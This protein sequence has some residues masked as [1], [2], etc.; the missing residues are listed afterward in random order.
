ML[1]YSKRVQM[2]QACPIKR[3]RHIMRPVSLESMTAVGFVV[4][5]LSFPARDLTAA[6]FSEPLG[7]LPASSAASPKVRDHQ[8]ALHSGELGS[9]SAPDHVIDE[10]H[11]VHPELLT[12]VQQH[13]LDNEGEATGSR[14]DSKGED[15]EAVH[16]PVPPEAQ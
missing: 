6:T 3:M 7:C 5:H 11:D 12:P 10:A 1:W 16:L 14:V 2:R 8:S 4:E 9:H 13:D 15:C